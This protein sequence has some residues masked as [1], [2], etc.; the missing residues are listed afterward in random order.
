VEW[1]IFSFCVLLSSGLVITA[2]ILSYRLTA[3]RSREQV[4]PWLRTWSLKGLLGPF[5]LW[6]LMNVGLSFSLQPFM[7]QIQAAQNKGGPWFPVFMIVVV[8]GLFVI[9]SY[10]SAVTLTWALFRAASDLDAEARK[11]FKSCCRTCV[12]AM[13]I[14]A[15]LLVLLGGW[16]VA[17][18]GITAVA[19]VTAGYAGALVHAAKIPPSYSRAVARIKFGKY[20]E[21]EWEIIREL[22]RCEDDFDGWMMMAD[23]YANHFHDLQE[24]QRTI[25]EI[26]EHPGTTAPQFSLALQRLADWHLKLADDAEG[27][28]RALQVICDR[29]PG[30]HLARMAQ[31]RINQLPRT[32]EEARERRNS[33]PIPLPALGDS[34]DA[35]RDPVDTQLGKAR[36]RELVDDCVERLK[37]DPNDVAAREK[38]ARLMAERLDRADLAIEQLTLLLEMPDQPDPKRADWLSL[39]A[40]WHLKY[41]DDH[42]AGRRSLETLIR[43]FPKTPQALAARRRLQLLERNAG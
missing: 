11:Q 25:A 6:I 18:L 5:V 4:I 21:A 28:R 42:E 36:A 8:A 15:V 14:P 32:A 19:A 1:D 27:A 22:E 13:C 30:T 9:S 29:L 41:R 37:A 2:W 24:A 39:I 16:T 38:L 35:Q 26:C 43:E 33:V 17:G 40:A 7:P 31:L 34:L 20:A 23:L 10:W 3:A 12:I